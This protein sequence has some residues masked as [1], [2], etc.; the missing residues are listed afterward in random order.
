[1]MVEHEGMNGMRCW[2]RC[3]NLDAQSCQDRKQMPVEMPAQ[4]PSRVTVTVSPDF[5]SWTTLTL[6]EY[7]VGVH[8]L[9]RLDCACSK[10]D[11]YLPLRPAVSRPFL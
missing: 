8:Y 11:P 3:W 1:M 7:T 2:I 6:Y 5:E 4:L 10:Q 9:D